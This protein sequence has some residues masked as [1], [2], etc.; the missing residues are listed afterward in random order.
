SAGVDQIS[1]VVQTNSATAEQ[2][3]A[4][5]EELASQAQ[6]LEEKISK[7]NNLCLSECKKIRN[8][9]KLVKMLI[10]K[11][12]ILSRVQYQRELI[13]FI[14]VFR[15]ND[16][17]YRNKLAE[18]K[19]RRG[20]ED[21]QVIRLLDELKIMNQCTRI[22]EPLV[23]K[24]EIERWPR[25]RDMVREMKEIFENFS[26]DNFRNGSNNERLDESLWE[27]EFNRILENF[28]QINPSIIL[29]KSK[30]TYSVVSSNGT[31]R[32]G[33]IEINVLPD[34]YRERE[35]SLIRRTLDRIF[36]REG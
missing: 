25:E 28:G 33:R 13:N 36:S 34:E 3:A 22:L 29:R 23:T 20:A 9:F 27:N 4:A 21:P 5:T 10:Q 30:D 24:E 2:T 7:F 14:T 35:R 11:S 6:L 18:I 15:R 1:E 26:R 17:H 32:G 12:P 16:Q 8:S 19:R 31:R